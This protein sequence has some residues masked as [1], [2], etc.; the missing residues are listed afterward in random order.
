MRENTDWRYGRM[1]LFMMALLRVCAIAATTCLASSAGAE[2]ISLYAAGSLRPAVEALTREA[3]LADDIEL[4]PTFGPAGALRQRIEAGE[5][6]D[7]FLSADMDAPRKLADEGRAILPAIAFAGN[8]MCLAAR[9]SAGVTKDNFVDRLL[10]EDLRLVTSAPMVD[11]G[12]DYAVATFDRVDAMRPGAGALL[13]AKAQH[14]MGSPSAPPI[15]GK[16]AA[17]SLFLNNLTDM[18]ILYCS[19]APALEREAPDVASLAFPP[20]LE[21]HPVS[22]MAVL[23]AKP[24]ALRLALFLLSE[25]G[26]AIIQRAG[27][28]PLREIAR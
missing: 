26:Q 1:D 15:P 7:L 17:A 27:L 12:G 21:V 22:G 14:L 18:A 9:R 3:G 4:K 20:E 10:A 13:R 23:S 6:A 25:K 28:L 16:S 19:G 5:G 11:P 24:G 8:R 2:T